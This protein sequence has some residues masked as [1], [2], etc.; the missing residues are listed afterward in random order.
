MDTAKAAANYA[1]LPVVVIPTIAT[2]DAPCSAISV[3]VVKAL[4]EADRVGFLETF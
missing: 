4:I 2:S 1:K 3:N